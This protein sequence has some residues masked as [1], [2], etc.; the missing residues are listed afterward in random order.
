MNSGKTPEAQDY[1]N[2]LQTPNVEDMELQL[3]QLVSQGTLSPE[4]ARTI[5]IEKSQMNNIQSDP[6]YKKS[7]MGA[8]SK[9]EELGNGGLSASD[10]ADL[11]R[12]QN[13]SDTANRGKR[14]AIIQ[15]A[16]ARGAGGSGLDIMAQLQNQQDSASNQSQRDMDVAS[17]ANKRSLDALISGGNLA[18]SMQNQDFNQQAQVAGANDAISKFNAQN[19]QNQ[20]NYN[21]GNRNNAQASNL[22]NAQNI[23][24]SNVGTRN[25]QQQFN[26]GLLQQ[27]Y[28]NQIQK[29]GGQAT[30]AQNNAKLQVEDSANKAAANNQ[31]ISIGAGVATGGA[32]LLAASV[33]AQEAAKKKQ[34]G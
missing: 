16:N 3:E 8:L 9:L 14:E 24:N 11:S 10:R 2:D 15:S 7:Q 21:I 23:S 26:K 32:G 1:Y 25:Q 18:S 22:N 34:G 33:A 19:M 12:I 17:M 31:M 13:Q 5:L 29:R 28:Q 4:E 6:A 27:E 20:T 30:V